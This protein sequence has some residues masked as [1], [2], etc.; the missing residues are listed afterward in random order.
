MHSFLIKVTWGK[1][2]TDLP[3]LPAGELPAA[4]LLD[5]RYPN[6][7]L[8]VWKIEEDSSNLNRV[9][10]ALAASKSKIN[11]ENVDYVLLEQAVLDDLGLKAEKSPGGTLDTT[12]NKDWHYDIIELTASKIVAIARCIKARTIKRKSEAEI[13]G[14]IKNALKEKHINP[15][16]ADEPLKGKLQALAATPVKGKE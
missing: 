11:I 1:W 8:S 13:K 2:Q 14:L 7:K 9:I 3:W 10:T 16:M 15:E 6:N 12:A 5:L 4:A